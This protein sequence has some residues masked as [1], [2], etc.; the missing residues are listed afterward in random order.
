MTGQPAQ[1]TTGHLM[2]PAELAAFLRVD[3]EYLYDL[4]ASG[5]GPEFIK[6]G[7]HVRYAWPDVRAWMRANTHTS[8]KAARRVASDG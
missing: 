4:R 2:T 8:T 3:Q 1:A 5:R 6:L 7:K